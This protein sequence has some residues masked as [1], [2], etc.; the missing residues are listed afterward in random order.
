VI[1]ISLTTATR[2]GQAD[3]KGR[4]AP[5]LQADLALL[6]GDPTTDVA[7]Y[8]NVRQTFRAGVALYR[9]P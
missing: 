8:S 9:K 2:F 7:A 1:L 3:R 6:E 4:I 5:G